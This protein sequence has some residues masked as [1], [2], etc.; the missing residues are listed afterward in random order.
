M[1]DTTLYPPRPADVPPDLTRPDAAYRGRVAAMTGGLFVFLVLYLVIIALAGLVA[2]GLLLIPMPTTGGRGVFFFL[3]L[4]FGGA[5]AAGLLCLFLVKGLFKGRRVERSSHLP[6]REAEHPELFAFIRRVYQDTGSRP[7]RRVY[8][9]PEV[10]AALIYDTSLLNLVVP[11]RKDLLIGLGLVNVVNLVEFKAVLAHEF[12]HF[13]QKSVGFGS[14]LYV[15]N[16]VMQDVIY[17]RDALDRLVDQWAAIDLRISFPAWGLKGVLWAVRG[18]LSGMYRSLNLLHL[19][20]S[21]QMEFNAD[22]VAVSVTGSDA[23]I[24]GLARLGFA[25]EALADAAQSLNAAADHG[26]F[27]DDLFY[28]QSKSAERLRRLRKNDRLGLPPE[29]PDDAAEPVR[30]FEPTDDGIPE[31]YRS[32]PT[33]HAREQN[34]KRVYVRSPRDDR[35]PWLLFGALPELKRDVTE[36]F[37]R[38]HLNRKERYDPRPAEEVQAFIDAEH[39]ETTYDPQYHGWY[40]DR[41]LNPG[42]LD[43]LPPLWPA[44]EVAGWLANWP[45]ADLEAR[46]KAYRQ[47]QGEEQ[48][49]RGLKSGE[50]SLKG[51]TFTFREKE[52]TIRDVPRLLSTVEEELK[53]AVESFHERD[54]QVLAAHR[55]AAHLLDGRTGQPGREAE[56]LDRYRFHMAVQGLLRGMLG[57]Q[58][59][60]HGVLNFLQNNQQMNEADINQVRDMLQEIKHTISE[61]LKDARKV[62]TPA[63]TNVSAGTPLDELI[64]DRSDTRLGGLEGN[65]ISGEWL[66]KLMNRLNGMVDR[67]KRLHFKSLGSLLAFQEHAWPASGRRCRWQ[68]RRT[69]RCRDSRCGSARPPITIPSPTPEGPSCSPASRSCSSQPR[70]SPPTRS[71]RPTSRAAGGSCPSRPRP[72]TSI[73]RRRGRPWSSRATR[74]CTAAK[75]SP[76]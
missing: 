20:L 11:P 40:D 32:H 22:N 60:L 36:V 28:H 25:N 8:V 61:N 52:C 27:S 49:L 71:R 26:V 53:A 73:C 75:R 69:S 42:D 59:R 34:A 57:E 13:A 66:G 70:W 19:S 10:N 39:A 21:R 15:A 44:D 4:K 18:I 5:V 37:Y 62:R 43:L 31:K 14:Y 23:L 46:T 9:S 65:T 76:G 35:L 51:K 6:L 67:L 47:H 30:V 2:Y 12:G 68:C 54:R 41:F 72:A 48:A 63:L 50:L 55:S 74:C 45:P 3:I 38:H 16:R 1:T 7:A 64:A 29:V 33:D 58:S 56:L 24:H 17:S